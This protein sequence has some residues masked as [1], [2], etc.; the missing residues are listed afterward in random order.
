MIHYIYIS[1]IHY[2][3]F[4]IYS[5]TCG[6]IDGTLIRLDE[7]FEQ[8]SPLHI[9]IA[10]FKISVCIMFHKRKKEKFERTEGMAFFYRL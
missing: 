9:L 10:W 4:P 7:L 8:N 1:P 3:S 6:S 5:E 2:A